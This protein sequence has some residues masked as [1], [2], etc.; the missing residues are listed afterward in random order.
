METHAMSSKSVCKAEKPS[1]RTAQNVKN[2]WLYPVNFLSCSNLN[3]YK[4]G[5]MDTT[6]SDRKAL[7]CHQIT[8]T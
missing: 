4:Y 8:V 7:M 5:F 2:N 6:V 1:N 3:K